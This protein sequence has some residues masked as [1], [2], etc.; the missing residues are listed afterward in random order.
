MTYS[1]ADS[2]VA[3]IAGATR[4]YDRA[5]WLHLM[6]LAGVFTL[7][8]TFGVVP[9]VDRIRRLVNEIRRLSTEIMSRELPA[10]REAVIRQLLHARS[11][12]STDD[13]HN[14]G[15]GQRR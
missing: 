15:R 2:R 11:Q 14:G 4:T 3:R 7:V 6:M 10:D 9:I 8:V 5:V 1:A 12:P 13:G